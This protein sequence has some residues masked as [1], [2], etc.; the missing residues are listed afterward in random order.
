MQLHGTVAVTSFTDNSTVT[1]A[2]ERDA[3]GKITGFVVRRDGRDGL[4]LK[5]AS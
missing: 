5:R 1:F 3:S 4:H 2:N